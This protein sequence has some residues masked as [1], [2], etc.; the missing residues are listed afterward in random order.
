VAVNQGSELVLTPSEATRSGRL[1]IGIEEPTGG[2]NLVSAVQRHRER[3]E[4]LA[5][6]EYKGAQE[7]VTPLGSAFW[8]RGRLPADGGL[9]EEARVM[10]VHP[11]GTRLLTLTYTYPA[12]NDTSARAEELLAVLGEIEP[13][14]G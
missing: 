8:S 5:D 10:A 7:L 3:F 1:E 4:A 9:S 6:G 2:V 12:G 11:S 13:G 14:Q